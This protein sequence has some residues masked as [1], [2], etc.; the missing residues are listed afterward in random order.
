MFA[1]LENEDTALVVAED[2]IIAENFTKLFDKI[3]LSRCGFEKGISIADAVD[4]MGKYYSLQEQAENSVVAI[5][6]KK[7][8][9]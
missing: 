8:D 3:D 5:K 2:I 4:E 7:I 6:I 1:N 9:S